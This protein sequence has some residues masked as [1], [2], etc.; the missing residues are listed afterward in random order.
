MRLIFLVKAHSNVSLGH[1]YKTRRL[2]PLV[3][4]LAHVVL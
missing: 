3:L 1:A 4:S 2:I